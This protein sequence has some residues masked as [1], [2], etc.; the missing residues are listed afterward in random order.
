MLKVI[1]FDCDGVM[2]D[3][4]EANRVYYNSLLEH[5]SCPLMTE[6][7][8]EYVHMYNSNEST[9]YI[10]RHHHHI[11]LEEVNRYR[12]GLDYAQ[13]MPYIQV[14]PDL[15]AFLQLIKPRFHTAISTNR[16]TMDLMMDTF[17]LRP[18]FDLVVTSSDVTR[19]K[20]A[21]DALLRILE[22]FQAVPEEAVYIGDSALDREHC[23]SVGIDLIAFK[24]EQL[25]AK[26]HVKS[27]ME[28]ATLLSISAT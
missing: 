23:A 1:I 27:F 14:E 10:F 19:P 5:F 4:R 28:I 16:T 26:Y 18:W 20:P 3:S 12:A 21:P 8:L 22:Q 13:F 11:A 25:E 15:Y 7:E 6:E 9:R 24:N 17:A 2:V